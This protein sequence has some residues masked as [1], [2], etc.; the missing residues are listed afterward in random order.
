MADPITVENG[1][2]QKLI[3]AKSYL[4]TSSTETKRTVYGHLSSL[5]CRLLDERPINPADILEEISYD[6]KRTPADEKQDDTLIDVNTDAEQIQLAN[7]QKELFQ[8]S[9][10]A[11]NEDETEN[12][13]P[14][15][16]ELSFYF[17]Q[18]GVGFAKDELYR[19]W[20]S[21]KQLYEK[22]NL[23][24]LRFWGKI[25]GTEKDYYVVESN[26]RDEDADEMEEDEENLSA[27]EEMEAA[28]QNQSASDVA[29]EDEEEED[30]EGD[31]D[32]MK[33]YIPKSTW[34]PPPPVP[35][36]DKG[37]GVNK[38]VFFVSN[39]P[40]DDWKKLPTV[41]PEQIKVSRSIKKFFTGR[42]DAPILSFPPFPGKEINYLRAQIARISAGATVSPSGFYTFD[43]EEEMNEDDVGNA[44]FVENENYEPLTVQELADP[45]G[46]NWVHHVQHILPQGR[47]N[48]VNPAPEKD[49]EEEME[50]EDDEEMEPPDT[51]EREIGPPLLT[52]ISSDTPVGGKPAWL[53]TLSSSLIPQYAVCIIR[54][55]L[56]PGACAFGTTK[57]FENIYIG[58]G[59]KY[60][61]E[62]IDPVL[63]P[64]PQEEFPSGPEITE[65]DDPTPEV[66]A[67]LQKQQEE[68]E[69]LEEEMEE[70]E[71]EE[72]EDEE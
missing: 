39:S 18:A 65:V 6:I 62:N 52:P 56:W 54:S 68:A 11:I 49:D 7:V 36:E 42:L 48:W 37:T 29:P 3:E 9:E 14:N 23:E 38:K 51:V 20:M 40:G 57:K 10:D 43:E 35:R 5:I 25:I 34:K 17:E 66:E 63:P 60:N 69:G 45:E 26:M 72:D 33:N 22:N 15:L 12:A 2:E 32:A 31:G 44:S 19:I 8:K 50:E 61:S 64:L 41:T 59:H 53:I 58:F 28:Q 1:R 67:A 27:A 46:N 47:C 55:N 4:L 13:F 70:E 71:E 30:E 24:G 21:I 16:L